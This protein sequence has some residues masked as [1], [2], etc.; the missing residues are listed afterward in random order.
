MS[1]YSKTLSVCIVLYNRWDHSKACMQ[2]IAQTVPSEWEIRWSVI[3]NG[4]TD[5]TK[6][7]LK[8]FMQELRDSVEFIQMLNES[9]KQTQAVNRTMNAATGDYM[10]RVDND[11]DFKPGWFEDCLSIIHDPSFKNVG[12]VCPTHHLKDNNPNHKSGA[13]TLGANPGVKIDMVSK[14]NANVPGNI[15][16]LSNVIM[17]IGGFYTPYN[18][19]HA[20]VH[21]CMVAKHMGYQ[22][23][24]TWNTHCPHVGLP[25]GKTEYSQRAIHE[26]RTEAARYDLIAKGD[27]KEKHPQE[28]EF[29]QQLTS[30][31]KNP[32]KPLPWHSGINVLIPSAGRRV[33]L[34]RMFKDVF[35]I[36]RWEGRVFTCGVGS[37]MPAAFESDEHFIVP[38]IKDEDEYVQAITAICNERKIRY[39][40]PVIDFDVKVLS[41]NKK[42]ILRLAGTEVVCPDYENAMKCFNKWETAQFFKS[43]NVPHPET[44]LNVE[45]IKLSGQFISKPLYGFASKNIKTVDLDDESYK[46]S[47]GEILQRKITGREYTVDCVSDR[48]FDVVSLVARERMYTRGG[49]VQTGRVV[50][51][52]HYHPYLAVMS[53]RLELVGPW[54][55]QYIVDSDGK[56][57]FIEINTRF[58]GGNPMSKRAG[59]DQVLTSLKILERD[60]FGYHYRYLVEWGLVGL[61]FDDCLYRHIDSEVGDHDADGRERLKG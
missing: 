9:I 24:Y 6:V 4:S 33:E 57:W 36:P 30:M 20:D 54:C 51:H 35:K 40:F 42:K 49:E 19:L 32:G 14:G 56:V 8:D 61:R 2:S 41:R 44:Y 17:D 34:V 55:A 50:N 38:A 25:D 47:D 12:F 16:G 28:I 59:Q 29:A 3:D 27:T 21:Y 43:V 53:K 52:L 15:F 13:L 1:Q 10:L 23:G 48:R 11:I 7:H 58:G 26:R 45:D 22:F 5:D 31:L 18:L 39:I 60:F 46:C 37:Y